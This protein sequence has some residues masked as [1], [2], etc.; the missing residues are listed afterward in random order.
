MSDPLRPRY[1]CKEYREEMTLLNLQRR[2]YQ[3]DLSEEEETR[4]K[5]SIGRLKR[6][7]GME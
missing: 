5:E 6:E 4:L 3:G 1:T 7:M 2:L